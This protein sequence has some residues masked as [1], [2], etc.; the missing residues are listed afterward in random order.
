MVSMRNLIMR[1][2]CH[3]GLKPPSLSRK[4]EN[5]PTH[6]PLAIK[7]SG[8]VQAWIQSHALVRRQGLQRRRRGVPLLRNCNTQLLNVAIQ[9]A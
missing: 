7:P 6:T 4:L 2:C 3:F 8:Q 1:T 9:L 5:P